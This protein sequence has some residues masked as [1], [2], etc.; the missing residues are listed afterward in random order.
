MKRSQTFFK[1]SEVRAVKGEDGKM[2]V[3]GYAA[4]FDSLSVPLWGFREKIAKG[5]FT[6]TINNKDNNIRALWNHN[7]DLVLGSTG[8]GTLTLSE[9]DKGLRFD[10]DIAP[11]SAGN[12]AFISIQRGDVDGVSFR[13]NPLKQEWDETD[14]ANVVRTLVEVECDEISPTPFPA[15]EATSVNTRTA[16]DD[17]ED[18]KALRDASM[19]KVAIANANELDLLRK[20]LSLSI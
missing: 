13:F 1:M 2:S 3:S 5:A 20:K 6:N 18:L 8:N 14:P 9:D 17:Y 19:Q 16:K 4:V 10:L 15:Y 11:T 7:S 12:D